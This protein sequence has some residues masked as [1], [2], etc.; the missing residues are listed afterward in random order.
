MEEES[1]AGDSKITTDRTLIEKW[2]EER[3]GRPAGLL[4]INFPGYSGNTALKEISWDEFFDTFEKKNLAFLYQ[5][6]TAKGEESRFF[7]FVS[8]DSVAANSGE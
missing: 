2:A 4:R 3:G 7:K 5:E 6:R 8:R 1:M